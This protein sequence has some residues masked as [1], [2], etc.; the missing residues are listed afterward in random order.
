MCP[1]PIRR[2]ERWPRPARRAA[3]PAAGYKDKGGQKPEVMYGAAA[4]HAGLG[5]LCLWRGF[6]DEPKW[7]KASALRGP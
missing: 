4:F 1:A 6:D 5:A 3:H 7:E 2:P